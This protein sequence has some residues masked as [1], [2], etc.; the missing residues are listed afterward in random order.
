VKR[1]YS[2]LRFRL[3]ATVFVAT[4]PALL[5]L[6]FTD[7]PVATFA[8]GL[9]ALA[10]AWFGGE[11]FVL[12]QVRMLLDATRRLSAGD[13]RSRS[14]LANEHSELGQLARAFDE[15][16][17]SLEEQIEQRN[18][19]EK[20]L[21]DRAQHQTVVAALGQLAL[22]TPDFQ[23]WLDHVA[24][25]IGQTLEVEFTRVLE[26]SP[27]GSELVLRAG[28][29]WKPNSIGQAS[30]SAT[31]ETQAGYSFHHGE[32]VVVTDSRKDGR[33]RTP[34]LLGQHGVVSGVT[35][36]VTLQHGRYGVLGAHS[37][38]PRA[39]TE[40]EIHMLL[41]V[42]MLLTVVLE[43]R[44]AETE[45]QKLANFARLNPN[46]AFELAPDGA[47]TYSNDAALK[48]VQSLRRNS[49]CELLPA[50]SFEIVRGCLE[51][52]RSRLRHETQIQ[53]RTLSWSFYPVPPR[54]VVH[55]YVQDIT[56][57][58]NLEAQLRQ[59]QKMESIGQL[60][61]GV[62]HDFNN[63][64]TI[65]QGHAGILMGK[66]DLPP[67]LIESARTVFFASERA[68]GLT[69][70]LL[71]FS[72]KSVMQPRPLDLRD[73][74]GDL[75]RMLQRLLGETITLEFLSPT[76]LPTVRADPS[77]IEQVLMNLVVNARDAMP[78]GGK[79]TLAFTE[80]VI[81][82]AYVAT[83]PRARPGRFVCLRVTDTGCG[84]DGATLE[85][86]F[87]PFFTTKEPGKGTGLGLATVYGIV[88]QHAG[89]VEVL[90]QVGTGTTFNV[91]LPATDDALPAAA[92]ASKPTA[93]VRGGN[94]RIL[95]VE[96]EPALRE[97]AV[98]LLE[99]SGYRVASAET[100]GEAFH[101]WQQAGGEF[102]L[103]LTD[104]VL[105]GGLTG[106]D[107]AE[108]LL[109]QKPGL[110]IVIISGYGTDDLSHEAISRLDAG[111]VSKPYT[112]QALAQAVRERL[113][114]RG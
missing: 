47:V 91:F 94:E 51:T 71:M 18:R 70:Q 41:S 61:A 73:V 52:G 81:D 50:D 24:L 75:S 79:L 39:F 48:L 46:P 25:F 45:V 7:A 114:R 104:M 56:E 96:D 64:L 77:M 27:D 42:S 80:A 68:A 13:L 76:R 62:A 23:E 109:A 37:T 53:D 66:S 9:L 86:I 20:T 30:E 19:A 97:M 98:M 5:V 35:V 29:G 44:R 11:R 49:L 15:M 99:S 65:I 90:S 16:A 43:R 8:V 92:S 54:Q 6:H 12:R 14:G 22:V 32:P 103:L 78:K 89:W 4:L 107:T 84:M 111:F 74:G 88:E 21:A 3:V 17:T 38:R 93:E 31:P 40:D 87:E 72:R 108:K 57:R 33:F 83:H 106:L 59:S 58:L 26:L 36:A 112:H 95:L 82:D 69:R 1:F 113:D 55:C 110:K 34:D 85:R 2:S 102:D 105:P 101:V 63:V 67:K 10:A 100:G 60:A 28:Q